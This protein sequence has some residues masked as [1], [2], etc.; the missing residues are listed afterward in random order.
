MTQLS[1]DTS[2]AYKRT[3][4]VEDVGGV[5][6]GAILVQGS[7]S[8]ELGCLLATADTDRFIGVADHGQAY[9]QPVTV[10][11]HGGYVIMTA[12]KAISDLNQALYIDASAPQRVT[13]TL[14]ATAG[15]YWRVGF[16]KSTT[17]AAGDQI[18]VFVNPE[19]VVVA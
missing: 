18:L 8:K 5:A 17:A 10:V 9:N 15:T 14:S 7:A 1:K 4:L 12:D 16:N 2:K 6:E 13:D 19:T 11:E 3:F